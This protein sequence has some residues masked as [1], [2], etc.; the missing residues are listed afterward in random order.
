MQRKIASLFR[1][2]Y[3]VA[4]LCAFVLSVGLL[5]L[6]MFPLEP[7]GLNI[8]IASAHAYLLR[9]DPPANAILNAPPQIVRMWFS[10]ELNPFTSHAVIVDTTNHEVDTGQGTVNSSNAMEM[11]VT[12]L[13]LRAGTYVVVWRSQ[14]AED[15]H[16][17]GS[18][19]I[20]RIARPD[21][22][23]PPV[24][25]I[26]PSGHFPGAAGTGLSANATLDGPTIMQTLM[27]WL[28]LLGMTFWVG[29]IFWETWILP[30][31]LQSNPDVAK[32]SRLASRRFHWLA[33]S[34]LILVLLSDI[35]IVVGQAAEVAGDWSGI[36]SLPILRAVL[37]GSHFGTVWWIRQGIALLALLVLLLAH[38]YSRSEQYEQMSREERE[39][40][41]QSGEDTLNVE[42]GAMPSWR[43][44]VLEI[45]RHIPALPRRL[46]AGWCIHSWVGRLEVLLGAALI[47]AFALSG[48]AAAVPSSQ[49]AYALSVDLLHLVC[50]TAW[51]GGLFYLGIVFVPALSSLT[52][53]QRAR[54]IALGLPEFSAVAIIS[55]LI[56]AV[57]GSLNTTIHL[58]ALAQLVTTLYG[59]ILTFKIGLFL[60]MIVISAYH[61]I[62]LRTCL[63]QVLTRSN[64]SS[65][66]AVSSPP[67]REG[68]SHVTAQID[69]QGNQQDTSLQVSRFT[70]SIVHWVQREAII[71]AGILLCV[72]L[73][74]AFAGTLAPALPAVAT[75]TGQFSGPFLQTQSIQGYS[76]TLKVAPDT[77]GTNTFTVTIADAH[78]H[79]VQGAAVLA[80]TTMLDMDMGSD[81]LQLQADPSSVGTFSG[82]S[83]LDM[84]GHWQVRLRILPPNEKTFVIVVFLFATR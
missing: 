75:K 21:G 84:A 58:T 45:F 51:V 22:S 31:T 17:T 55:V 82:Q 54:V 12:P 3:P 27:T 33:F 61:S 77:F 76:V 74:G 73:L 41:S 23:V 38:K 56:L 9:S 35:G 57:T 20:F 68:A 16:I 29:G 52:E 10:E 62:Y 78:G 43:S 47:L 2:P 8:P 49:L 66:V 39:D 48:H 71:G 83:G 7:L 28:A 37:F 14:S 46:V 40:V 19:F 4:M 6:T 80:E 25:D 13:L 81:A 70:R 1:L 67:V 44:A 11:D 53:S 63:V 42:I 15:G 36:F 32:V 79:P 59:G 5:L 64:V 24:P 50:T 72:A 34:A 26:L 69:E 65:T 30:P 18:S 60:V